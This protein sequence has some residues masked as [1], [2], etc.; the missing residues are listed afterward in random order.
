MRYSERNDPF[1]LCGNS[2]SIV[3]LKAIFMKISNQLKLILLIELMLPLTLLLLGIYHGLMQVI[4]RAGLLSASS[5]LKLDYYQGLT[6]HG[7][8][9]A[10]VLTTFF[11]V[12]FGH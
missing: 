5:M 9:N 12:A 7:M 4:Y 10:V 6:L 3:L 2:Y 8:I 11:A 1:D